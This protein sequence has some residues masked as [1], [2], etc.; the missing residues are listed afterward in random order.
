MKGKKH[1]MRITC[2]S[3]PKVKKAIPTKRAYKFITLKGKPKYKA[4]LVALKG[5]NKYKELIFRRFSLRWSK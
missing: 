3:Y 4:R 1:S 5:T 2:G